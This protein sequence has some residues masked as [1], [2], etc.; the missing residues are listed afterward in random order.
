MNIKKVEVLFQS[1][2][3]DYC[4]IIIDSDL[5]EWHDIFNMIF[6]FD[7]DLRVLL[8]ADD[9]N[10]MMLEINENIQERVYIIGRNFRQKELLHHIQELFYM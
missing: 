5:Y 2:N 1:H 8:I 6:N 7:D 4:G 3:E 9:V 10:N